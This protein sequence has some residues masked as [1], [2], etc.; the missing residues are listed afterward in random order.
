[1][2]APRLMLAGAVLAATGCYLGQD[3]ATF[4]PAHNPRGVEVKARVGSNVVVG[5]LLE[6]RPAGLLI[7]GRRTVR[8][9]ATSPSPADRRV[10][11]IQYAHVTESHFRQAD[12]ELRDGGTPDA[13]SRSHLR[14]LSRFPQGLGADLLSQLLESLGQGEVEEVRR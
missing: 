12:V 1:M 5:E 2:T 14:R 13:E 10:L 9:E 4:E 7:L 3:L 8:R 6:V 11:F